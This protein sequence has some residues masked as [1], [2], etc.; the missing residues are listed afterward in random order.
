MANT[1]NTKFWTIDPN[2]DVP[3]RYGKDGTAALP[4]QTVIQALQG[5]CKRYGTKVTIYLNLIL[6]LNTL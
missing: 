3:I 4:A 2:E 6:I 1:N 5:T